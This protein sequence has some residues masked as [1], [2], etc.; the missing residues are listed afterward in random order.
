MGFQNYVRPVLLSILFLAGLVSAAI[1]LFYLK[2]GILPDPNTTLCSWDCGWYV[3]LRDNGYI[4]KLDAE[5]NPAFFPLFSYLWKWTSFSFVQMSVVNALLFL[6]SAGL[7]YHKFNIAPRSLLIF[8]CIGLLTF[9]VVPYSESLF[10][11]GSA[12]FL[13]GLH[14]E[15]K[16]LT[17]AGFTIA[18]LAR[19]ASI[20]FIAASAVLLIIALVQKEKPKIRLM[21][22]AVLTT[23]LCTLGVMAIQY[24]Q[25]GNFFAFF[26][27][28]KFWDHHLG[29]PSFPLSSWHWPTHLSDSSGLLFGLIAIMISLGFCI[30]LIFKT[31]TPQFLARFFSQ[32]PLGFAYLFAFLYLAGTTATILLFQGGNIHSLNRYVFS[33]PFFLLFVNAFVSNKINVHFT[34]VQYI[35][36]A[37]IL[38]IFLP[39]QTY[40]EHYLLVT[41]IVILIP[42]TLLFQSRTTESKGFRFL[43][44]FGLSAGF[45]LQVF[46]LSK[47]FEGNWMG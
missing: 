34:F 28:Q 24:Y 11:L 22:I 13:I 6:G 32:E 9:F 5:S 8:L 21:V 44:Y 31:T 33:T 42:A 46:L 20:I 23:I 30:S 7:L 26:Y 41:A 16:G 43:F 2:N 38:G 27:A 18:V 37:C 1:I 29:I 40:V 17:I 12:L 35:V 25:T 36:F 4:L 45:L 10:F 19:S 47:Y 3:Y 39:R 15:Q 14:K